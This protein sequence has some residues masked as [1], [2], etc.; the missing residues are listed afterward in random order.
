MYYRE[1]DEI[2]GEG[3]L[4]FDRFNIIPTQEELDYLQNTVQTGDLQKHRMYKSLETYLNK[5]LNG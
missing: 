2:V 5:I 1:T 4:E 3:S